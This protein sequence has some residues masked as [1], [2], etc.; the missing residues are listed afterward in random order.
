MLSALTFIGKHSAVILAAGVV[1][2]FFLPQLDAYLMPAFPFLV[3]ALLCIAFMRVDIAAVLAQIRKPK[4]LT[5]VLLAM[6]VLS[7]LVMLGIVRATN[8]P[9]EIALAMMMFACAP[10]LASTTNIAMM[11]GLNAAICLNVTI[12]GA[13][14]LPFIAP[15]ILTLT[16]SF[17]IALDPWLI[18]TRLL[19]IVGGALIVSILLRRLLGVAR[20]Q[21]HGATFDGVTTLL[22]LAFLMAVM[23]PGGEVLIRDPLLALEICAIALAINFGT[24][25]L[26]SI[27]SELVRNRRIA[28]P[29]RIPASIGLIAGNRNFAL[30]VPV[31]PEEIF[32]GV[33]V[34]LAF[35]QVPIYLTPL[36]ERWVFKE[37]R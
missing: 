26:F 5:I 31:L 23:G 35:Y 11:I 24:N 36:L 14:L 10:P 17:E 20:I 2:A 8:P 13:I 9:P 1:I 25:I 29:G 32:A 15:P 12:I 37:L 34:F 4:L 18:F 6:F 19:Y 3:S 7:P 16:A 30:M 28:K 22:L 27:G 33:V 21:A